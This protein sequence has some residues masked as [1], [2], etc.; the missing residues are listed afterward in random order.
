MRVLGFQKKW[1]KLSNPEFTTFRF[2]RLDADW[3]VGEMV[4]VYFKS[5]SP[6]RE[7][8]GIAEIINKERR[9]LDPFSSV[10]NIP[11]VTEEEANADGFVSL[12][13]MAD[14]M[15]RQYGLDYISLF[16]KLT[17]RWFSVSLR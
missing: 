1:D 5:R 17:L 4:Q 15:E 2:Q 3:Q 9:E 14:Y 16:N 8:L 7:K 11:I 13:A 12:R 6:Q 10:Y